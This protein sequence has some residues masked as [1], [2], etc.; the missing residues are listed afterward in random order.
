MTGIGA[1]STGAVETGKVRERRALRFESIDQM[2]AE[3]DRLVKAERTGRLRPLGNWTLG[4]V[5]GHLAA[6]VE[7]SFTG[8]P[9]K[10]PW[11]VKWLLRLRKKAFL[12]GPMRAGVKIPGVTGGTLATN[13][14]PVEAALDRLRRALDR[15]K[16]EAPTCPNVI[17]GPLTH[18]EWIALNLRHAELHLSFLV[19]E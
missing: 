18:E 11:L 8:P 4:Q 19:T 15:L 13:P 2:M 7:Y 16:S 12:Y 6:W 1:V 14:L 3:V 10:P 9:L 17:F 5:L